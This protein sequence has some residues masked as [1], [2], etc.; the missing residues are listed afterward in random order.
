MVTKTSET[1]SCVAGDGFAPHSHPSHSLTREF[2]MRHA[3][4]SR[5][6]SIVSAFATASSVIVSGA[7]LAACPSSGGGVA[8]ASQPTDASA[9]AAV[10]KPVAEAT[11][12]TGTVAAPMLPP[13][14]A[15]APKADFSV[16]EWGLLEYTADTAELVTAPAATPTPTTP[17][18]APPKPPAPVHVIDIP[19]PRPAARKP[20]VYLR[21]GPSWDPAT[22]VSVVVTMAGVGRLH[23]VW[24]TPANGPQPAHGARFAW[25]VNSIRAGSCTPGW[26]PAVTAPSCASLSTPN[27]CEAALFETWVPA[28]PF[29]LDVAGTAAPALLYNGFP[30]DKA[31]PVIRT[32]SGNWKNRTAFA[33][34]VVLIRAGEKLHRIDG[35][36][37]GAEATLDE[38]SVVSIAA[39]ALVESELN[40]LLLGGSEAAD[41]MRAWGDAIA[42]PDWQVFG[43]LGADAV[44]AV[45]TLTIEPQPSQT[46]RVMAFLAGRP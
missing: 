6:T 30:A 12:T 7:W 37:A 20:V 22:S 19:P 16:I 4:K 43:F 5:S 39:T 28:H 35:L 46:V 31:P 25:R 18:P 42:G 10:V 26:G 11:D 1:D 36:G 45:S 14:V 27:D 38:K 41:F 24:P 33:L 40:R 32:E 13:A 29:C 9:A 23:E 3:R 44:D 21:P 34:P 17:T 15:V 2:A 8:P